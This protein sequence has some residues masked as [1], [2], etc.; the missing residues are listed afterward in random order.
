MCKSKCVFL[1][2]GIFLWS[3]L[4]GACGGGSG[5][6]SHPDA[7]CS[8][9][10]VA[11]QCDDGRLGTQCTPRADAT[12]LASACVCTSG[13]D[14][15]SSRLDS[16]ADLPRDSGSEL[17]SP[18]IP[19]ALSTEAGSEF[20]E[21]GPA[22]DAPPDSPADLQPMQAGDGAQE[23]GLDL[24]PA[25]LADAA[26]DA[27]TAKPETAD[28]AALD[29]P[30]G[31]PD[32]A[33]DL[34]AEDAG[35][36]A[37]TTDDL[38]P[39]AAHDTPACASD[40]PAGLD[41]ADGASEGATVAPDTARDLTGVL[42]DGA[43][44][45][46]PDAAAPDSPP[47]TPIIASICAESVRGGASLVIRGSGF[48]AA[49]A[50]NSVSFA[51]TAVVPVSA[52]TDTLVVQTPSPVVAGALTVTVAGL[53]SNGLAYRVGPLKGNVDG[54]GADLAAVPQG[55]ASS[56]DG[57]WLALTVLAGG[58]NQIVL[59]DR[60]GSTTTRL[61][62]PGG[63]TPNGDM[64][65]PQISADGRWL[66]FDSTASN[67]VTGDNNTVADIF[68]YQ[69]DTGAITRVSTGLGGDETNGP[70]IRPF[71][72]ASG[73]FVVFESTASNLAFDDDNSASDVFIF[74]REAHTI[75]CLSLVRSGIAGKTGTTATGSSTRPVISADGYVIAYQSDATNLVD[76]DT[77]AT[78]DIFVY[79]RR[80]SK[81]T[82]VSVGP[83]GIQANG[84]S[85]NPSLTAD[86]RLVVFT[87]VATDLVADTNSAADVFIYD[88][89][90]TPATM[91]RVSVTASGD[92]AN[93][94]S[95][96]S[97]NSISA[98]GRY[99]V[100][101]SDA[102]NLVAGDNNFATDVFV[103]DRQAATTR[104]LSVDAA[105]NEGDGPSA[106]P[107]AS[108]DGLVALS[109][110]GRL[111]LFLTAASNLLAGDVNGVADVVI[112]PNSLDTCPPPALLA[113]G[114]DALRAGTV[115]DLYGYSFDPNPSGNAVKL[116]AGEAVVHT[117][118]SCQLTVDA[119][120]S[121]AAGLLTVEVTGAGTSN[122]LTYALAPLRA[123]LAAAGAWAN[124]DSSEAS[125]SADGR[126][127]VFSSAATN[128][129]GGHTANATDVFV[130]DRWA[131]TTTRVNRSSSGVFPLAG[132]SSGAP[133][134]SAD[135][136]FVVYD[137]QAG[138][139]VVGDTNAHS[140]VFVFDMQTSVTTRA[141]V[142]S[143]GAQATL[144]S[145]GPAVSPDGRFVAFY[146]DA[147]DLVAGDSNGAQDV[148]VHERQAA[149]TTLVSIASDGTP[150]NGRSYEPAISANGRFVAFRSAASTLVAG[151]TNLYDDIFLRD[152][153]A[154][155]TVR[156][157][158]SSA[159]AQSNGDSRSVAM[160]ADGHL[161]VFESD[162]T[163]LVADDS[164]GVTDIFL[165]DS[166]TGATTRVSLA[167]DGSNANGNSS[168]PSISAD[169][170][171]IAFQ[172]DASN[173]VAGDSGGFTDIF[174][175]D[176]QTGLT[177]RASTTAD[178][179]TAGSD[180][181]TNPFITPEGRYVVFLSR[182]KNLVG[183]DTLSWFDVFLTARSP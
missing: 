7:K 58:H 86:G 169:G 46:N 93:G 71:P 138:N 15:G 63:V 60:T 114:Q 171:T 108:A 103:R 140:D 160:S 77:N 23:R 67:L 5:K 159:G 124:N 99:V 174:V 120:A 152:T 168:H 87:S 139:L 144:D 78:T 51:G 6:P 19:D 49:P 179:R 73:R 161:L 119:P 150:G 149:T 164:N 118:S 136:R 88:R 117:A 43:P 34:A 28:A 74:D 4:G 65:N 145:F 57:R 182:A 16:A 95:T 148:F 158:V 153:Q 131:A 106:G 56:A 165:H 183:A 141:S 167:S 18:I 104:R 146:S 79:D 27:P 40:L 85:Y 31:N 8:G 125:A 45:G 172:S 38:A 62:A 175:Y 155:T 105:G 54:T 178:S 66:V 123:N 102:R 10:V 55:L 33:L 24:P 37:D 80:T 82:R 177:T 13:S 98:D 81:N 89:L 96:S 17:G 92:E 112:T 173:I 53:T 35:A 147:P 41:T 176:R 111:A 1:L 133:Q 137:S 127:V 61:T 109:P 47:A 84:A 76:L 122:A 132:Y 154:A 72:S 64:N 26:P 162:A 70:S 68:L 29:L 32:A 163:N 134:I 180:V 44:D 170:R 48:S 107:V 42:L 91:A 50:N 94:A 83:S 110:D 113:A 130:F 128:I 12:P 59:L 39:D 11:C 126:L 166:L 116:G 90:A 181:S 143:A 101:A 142:T 3:I 69:I 52:Q 151:D 30:L 121:L 115:L 75:R 25:I 156:I 135:G 97:R 157:S 21:A 129:V 36:G 14:G 100:F 20:T 22:L 9:V 2:G